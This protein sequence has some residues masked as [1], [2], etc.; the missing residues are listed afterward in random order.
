M[1]A[2][3]KDAAQFFI[4]YIKEAHPS[5]AWVMRVNPRIKYIK[6]PTNFF[7]RFQVANTCV[8]DLEISIPCLVDDMEN[9]TANAYKGFPD[10]L[11][12][13]GKDGNVAFTGGPG[14]MGFKPDEIETALV[15][16]LKKIGA[17]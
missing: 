1:Y 14:P 7:E 6:D 2:D 3:Y 9:S 10:R 4:I 15:E 13:I 5:D 16:E 8:A 17:R 11:F 12:L